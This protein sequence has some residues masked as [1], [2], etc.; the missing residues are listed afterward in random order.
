[1]PIWPGTPADVNVKHQYG[2]DGSAI[3]FKT[4][5]R[6]ENW[7]NQVPS[8]V[9]QRAAKLEFLHFYDPKNRLLADLKIASKTI[10][11][12]IQVFQTA[13]QIDAEISG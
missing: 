12:I 1:M 13:E 5:D 6:T 7:W 8:E 2:V 11:D 3:P 9:A 4:H 10:Q